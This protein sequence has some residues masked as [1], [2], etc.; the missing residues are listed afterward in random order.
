MRSLHGSHLVLLHLLCQFALHIGVRG[1]IEQRHLFQR[2]RLELF[3]ND[4]RL[5]AQNV[6]DVTLRFALQPLQTL[7]SPLRFEPL[8]AESLGGV[9]RRPHD[10]GNP[11]NLVNHRLALFT[12]RVQL[13][14]HASRHLHRH[15]PDGLIET[16]TLEQSGHVRRRHQLVVAG[17]HQLAKFRQRCVVDAP[18][19]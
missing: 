14:E 9:G 11:G 15:E 13:L 19:T 10:V 5:Q 3:R 8:R 16:A 1:Q 7:G 2:F 18:N 6:A 17:L 4:F 12:L